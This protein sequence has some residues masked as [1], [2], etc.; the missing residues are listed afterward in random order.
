[1]TL[2]PNGRGLLAHEDAAYEEWG[3]SACL[4]YRPRSDGR[5]LS[6]TMGSAWGETENGIEAMWAQTHAAGPANG[7]SPM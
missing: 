4:A 5:G 1:M 2:E 3:L 6:V 7:A